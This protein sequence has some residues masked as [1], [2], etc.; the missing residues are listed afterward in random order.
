MNP[1]AISLRDE[2]PDDYRAIHALTQRAFQPMPFA[3]GDEQDL[4]DALRASGA[5]S[6]SLVAELDDA[7]VGHAA[8]SPA[9][10]ADGTGNWYAL[11]PVSVE[12]GLQRRGIGS[13]LI[14]EGLRRLRTQNAA[15]C[16]LVGSPLYYPRFGF[17]P[18][19]HLAPPG[20]P[21]EYF[22]ILPL[23]CAAPDSVVAFHSLFHSGA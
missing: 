17:Q 15:G 5:L 11:G 10:T 2:C 20:E 19:P 1:H 3:A 8:F 21:P 6:I 16:I 7:L 18:F 22:M 12:P 14:N 4:I 13:L 23:A 9:A